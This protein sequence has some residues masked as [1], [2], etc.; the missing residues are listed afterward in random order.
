MIENVL[1]LKNIVSDKA[2]KK[3]ISEA[4]KRIANLSVVMKSMPKVYS[5]NEVFIWAQKYN[6]VF[7]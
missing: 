4:M 3:E 6:K 1:I 7:K 2:L 5:Q